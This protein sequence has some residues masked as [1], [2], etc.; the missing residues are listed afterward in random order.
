LLE[1]MNSV[2][3][4][5]VSWRLS[6]LKNFAIAD[7]DLYAIVQPTLL[8]VS[9]GDRLLP[10]IDEARRL[11]SLLPDTQTVVLPESGHACLLEG[12]IY[13]DEIM[14]SKHFNFERPLTEISH[15]R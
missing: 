3:P 5:V 6:L 8:I 12:D 9:A 15:L 4:R 14:K 1:A 11:A 13:L 2:P 10:S 7:I